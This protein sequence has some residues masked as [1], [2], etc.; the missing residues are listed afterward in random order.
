MGHGQFVGLGNAED[1]VLP[2]SVN[3]EII[4]KIKSIVAATGAVLLATAGAVQ[5]GDSFEVL[6]GIEAS[7]M[8]QADLSGITGGSESVVTINLTGGDPV[9]RGFES[10]NFTATLVQDPVHPPDPI[11]HSLTN[12][13]IISI[14]TI[15]SMC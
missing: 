10:T 5:A 2:V 9:I 4:M 7:E 8:S 12:P 14:R 3:G 6:S 1:M 15:N 13:P 11:F